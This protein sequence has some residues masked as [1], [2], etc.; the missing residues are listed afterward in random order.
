ML[1]RGADILSVKE[2]LGHASLSSTQIYTHMT[3]ERLRE[4]YERSHP[5]AGRTEREGRS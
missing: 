4:I 5:R 1:D 3:V 2:L